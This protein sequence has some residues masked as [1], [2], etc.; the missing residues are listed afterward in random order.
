MDNLNLVI[1][2]KTGSGKSTLINAILGEKVAPVRSGQ[3][4]TKENKVYTKSTL[5]PLGEDCGVGR[6]GMVG[7]KLN[8]YDTVGLEIDSQ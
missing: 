3:A 1:I 5:L 6:Y 7:K 4:V 8:L 2:G